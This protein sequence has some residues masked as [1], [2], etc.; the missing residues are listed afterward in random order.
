LNISLSRNPTCSRKLLKNSLTSFV[1]IT[2]KKNLTR[3][4][5]IKKALTAWLAASAAYDLLAFL[6]YRAFHNAYNAGIG[7]LLY[8]PFLIDLKMKGVFLLG[9]YHF[10]IT[11]AFVAGYIFWRNSFRGKNGAEGIGAGIIFGFF[12]WLFGVVVTL[13]H[14]YLVVNITPPVIIYWITINFINYLAMG[15]ITGA[16]YRDT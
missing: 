1:S 12:I 4:L 13:L 10:I 3:S 15:A 6:A 7:K 16:I 9:A 2:L 8:R 14:V 11:G 5:N